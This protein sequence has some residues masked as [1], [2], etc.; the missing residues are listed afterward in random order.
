M[1]ILLFGGTG[2][3]GRVLGE[4]L[5]E[6]G[7]ELLAPAHG[8]C[9]LRDAA[10]VSRLV[11]GCGAEAVVNAAAISGPESC[12]DDPLT[13]HGVNAMAP[14]A[15][16]LACRHTGARLIHLSTDYVLDGRRA[17]LKDESAKCRPINVYGESKREGELEVLEALPEALVV[18]VSWI[19]GNP[20]K[21][22]FVESTLAK[23]L[24]A[25][26]LAAIADKFSL[27]TDARD[28]AAA[29]AALL[30]EPEGDRTAGV[31]Q[32]CSGG[33]PMSWHGCASAALRCAVELG[34]LPSMP[35]LRE[36]R[37]D[38]ASFFRD[39]RPRHTA[40]SNARLAARLS[41]LPGAP[42]LPEAQLCLRRVTERY[43]RAVGAL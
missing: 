3:C 15:M 21:P 28:I 33:E 25:Q 17:G 22:S 7:H 5:S 23:A 9:D 34:A 6:A 27:P 1:K 38:E 8:D 36:Q 37:L 18:R 2:R 13:A 24:A 31:V 16:A 43:L 35:E 42:V 11:L 29:L 14:A 10:A 12:L 19:C 40:M 26:P 41:R 4:W 30:Q 20:Q 32:L 39:A